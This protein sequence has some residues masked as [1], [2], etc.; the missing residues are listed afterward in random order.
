VARPLG[1]QLPIDGI[2]PPGLSS[3]A[4]PRDGVR[5]RH[6]AVLARADWTAEPLFP[7]PATEPVPDGGQRSPR[8]PPRRRARRTPAQVAAR[9]FAVQAALFDVP[10]TGLPP[11]RRTAPS[12][13]RP[14]QPRR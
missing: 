11:P 9:D 5:G 1:E 12:S 6:P 14:R 10:E 8:R 13:G 3:G 4:N 7:I 2:A